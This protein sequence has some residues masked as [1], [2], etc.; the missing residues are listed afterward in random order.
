VLHSHPEADASKTLIMNS[1]PND[2]SR[3]GFVTGMG[4]GI[5]A[6]LG[7]PAIAQQADASRTVSER[8][9]SLKNPAGADVAFNYLPQE[10]SDAK[11]VVQL[12]R[13][14]GRKAVALPGDLRN[15][16]FCGELAPIFVLL[17]SAES[18]YATGQVYGAVGGR[19]G[20]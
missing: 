1:E 12:I 11:E 19:G 14:A 17:A 3:R 5:A 10:E 2:P 18:S 15:E 20:P 7:G 16:S 8:T 9:T 13:D 4:A 6:V